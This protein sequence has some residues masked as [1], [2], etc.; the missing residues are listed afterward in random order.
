[1]NTLKLDSY[2]YLF[3]GIFLFIF[4]ISGN[5]LGQL[6]GCRLIYLLTENIVTKH[7]LGFLTLFLTLA[8]TID[9]KTSLVELFK[10]CGILYIIF[11]LSSKT[12]KYI[13]YI[14]IILFIISFVIQLYKDRLKKKKQ[15]NVLTKNDES[16]LLYI[17]I[18]NS[19]ILKIIF[20]LIIIGVIIYIG[21]QKRSYGDDFNY[22]TFFVGNTTCNEGQ[23]NINHINEYFTS[24]KHVF[25]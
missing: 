2:D 9:L 7:L 12:T 25:K 15:K 4:I 17:N 5:Y 22:Y 1:M 13:N 8:F 10:I 3:K 24:I 6:L 16:H 11:T 21:E 20:L 23:E 18:Y 19:Y 14:L